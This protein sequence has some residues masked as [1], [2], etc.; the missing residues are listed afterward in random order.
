MVL[1]LGIFFNEKRMNNAFAG[2]RKTDYSRS[3]YFP[4]LKIT[5][6]YGGYLNEDVTSLPIRDI[7]NRLKRYLFFSVPANGFIYAN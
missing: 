7:L 3:V 5:G 1:V 4:F 6:S 2:K